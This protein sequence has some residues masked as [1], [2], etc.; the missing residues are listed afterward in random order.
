MRGPWSAETTLY[1]VQPEEENGVKNFVYCAV[2][3]P[4]YDESGK[5]IVVTINNGSATIQATKVVFE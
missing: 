4:Y 1:T 2:A 3:N 5:S